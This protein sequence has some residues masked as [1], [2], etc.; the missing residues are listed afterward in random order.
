VED[1]EDFRFVTAGRLLLVTVLAVNDVFFLPLF[2]P[3]PLLSATGG[4]EVGVFR[5]AG[6]QE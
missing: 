1:C 2:F 6:D 4:G 3:A 5:A